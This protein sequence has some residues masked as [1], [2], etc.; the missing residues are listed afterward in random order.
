MLF[1][2]HSQVFHIL[3]NAHLSMQRK[4]GPGKRNKKKSELKIR[5]IIRY[6][7]YPYI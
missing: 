1:V 6:E 3:Y 4:E 2:A 7:E 5:G